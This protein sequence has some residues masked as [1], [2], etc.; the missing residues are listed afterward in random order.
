MTCH[1]GGERLHWGGLRSTT[2]TSSPAPTATTRWRASPPTGCCAARASPRPA[3]PATRSS[4]PNSASART[5]RCPKGKMS[6]V[7][8]HNPHGSPTRPLLKA[9]SVNDV[10]YACHAEKRGPML[11]EHAPVRENCINCHAGARLEPRQ[12]ARRRASLPLPAVPHLARRCMRASSSA[13]TRARSRAARRHAEPA[14]DRPLLPELPH[15]R[16]TAATIRPARGSSA[17]GAAMRRSARVARPRPRRLASRRRPRRRRPG[18]AP[19]NALNPA[20]VNPAHRRALDGRGRHRARASPRRA[21]P[22]ASS[23]TSRSIRARKPS[24]KADG[25]ITT[26]FVELGGSASAATRSA[27][28]GATTRTC[29][30]G[31]YLNKF[32]RHA[33]RSRARRASSRRPA[34]ASARDD[35]FYRVQFGRYNDW[36]VTACSTTARR[37]CSPRPIAR[38]GTGSG[39][40]NLAPDHATPGRHDERGGTTQTNIQ[41]ALAATRQL[42]ARGGP[43]EGRRARRHEAGRSVEGST[44]ASPTRSARARGLSARSSAAAAAAA[45]WRSPESIDY[46]THDF[47]AGAAVQRRRSTASTCA[48][49][50]RSSATSVDTHDVPEPG[51]HHAERQQRA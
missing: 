10:C 28:A 34:A 40:D 24:E 21:R 14:H 30:D 32:A 39:S 9:D 7:D 31:A 3:R 8:C 16:S 26:G 43:Q 6:C 51:L 36:K 41:N 18:P 29:S 47:T 17:D 42:G 35:Q 50:P 49:R 22:P 45:T 48:P 23:T 25:W 5:C 46:E 44:R 19:G 11:W 37:R 12:A 15:A 13:A 27:R 33:A 4:A 1:K 20:P 38:S 2:T